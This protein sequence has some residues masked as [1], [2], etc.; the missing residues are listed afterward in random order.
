[1]ECGSSQ[2]YELLTGADGRRVTSQD[3]GV[4]GHRCA[5]GTMFAPDLHKR[6]DQARGCQSLVDEFPIV[7]CDNYDGWATVFDPYGKLRSAQ[8]CVHWH[9][10]STALLW[11]DA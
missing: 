1:M 3:V 4:G 8:P 6:D 2:Y 5:F 7:L 11:S 9:D 10:D